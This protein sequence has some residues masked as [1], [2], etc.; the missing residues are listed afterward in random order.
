MKDSNSPAGNATIKQVERVI[1]LYIKG[2]YM[3]DS[4]TPA[5]NATIKQV[6]SDVLLN[7]KGHMWLFGISME[8]PSRLSA[9]AFCPGN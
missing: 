4:N 5:G 6:Q 7:T 3:K 8:G 9:K 2:Q 1:L